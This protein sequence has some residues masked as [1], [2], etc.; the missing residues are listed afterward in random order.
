MIPSDK[1]S[2]LMLPASPMMMP[3]IDEDSKLVKRKNT[4][5]NKLSHRCFLSKASLVLLK[6]ADALKPIMLYDFN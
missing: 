4:G 3:A 2:T 1:F 5:G 6:A